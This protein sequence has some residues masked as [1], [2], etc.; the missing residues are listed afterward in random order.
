MS[1]I[2]ML[3]SLVLYYFSPSEVVPALAPFHLQQIILL[4]AAALAFVAFTMRGARLPSPHYILMLGL[5]FAV[6][7]SLFSKLWIRDSYDALFIFA[8]LVCMYFLVLLNASSPLRI[9]VIC[10]TIAGCALLM[11]ILGI[12]AYH[13]GFQAVKLLHEARGD[14]P[15]RI[16][17]Y[18]IL[19]DANDLAQFFLVGLAMLGVMWK[20]KHTIGNLAKLIPPAAILIYGVFLTGSRA[21]IFGLAVIVFS[22]A[23]NRMGKLQSVVLTAC[24]IAILIA[25]EF[26]GG[27]EISLDEG[28]AG[29]RVRAWGDGIKM[30]KSSPLFGIG[31]LHFLEADDMTAHNSFVLCFAELGMFGYF[32]WLALVVTVILGLQRIARAPVKTLQDLELRPCVTTIRTALY[33][34]LVTSWFLSRTYNITLYVLLALAA[35]LIAQ[36]QEKNPSNVVTA[37]RWMAVTLASQAASIL[38]IYGTIRLRGLL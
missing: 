9:R 29:E 38:F 26:G 24:V 1:L 28:S 4:P 6:I 32:F 35:G 8:L 34:F 21:A 16:R 20:P 25:S 31:Y 19:G 7:M 15:V 30:L 13:T 23:A 27:R 18:G 33:T 14:Q 2:L 37:E 12:L 10:R 11:A 36:Y 17:G 22:L 3:L 5:W